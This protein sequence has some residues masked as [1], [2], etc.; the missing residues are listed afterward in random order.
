MKKI[1][2]YN[3]FI[4][5]IS[6]ISKRTFDKYNI[7]NINNILPILQE[8]YREYCSY[9]SIKKGYD[10][11]YLLEALSD[12][13]ISSKIENDEISLS[14]S[15]AFN[16]FKKLNSITKNYAIIITKSKKE[17][18]DLHIIFNGEFSNRGFWG[19]ETM[20]YQSEWHWVFKD[21]ELSGT[22]GHSSLETAIRIG[23]GLPIFYYDDY[24][25]SLNK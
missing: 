20:N 12:Y 11:E 3:N 7:Q 13:I 21:N 16:H 5:E 2:K 10:Y 22:S 14:I 9:N 15:L 24:L 18:R 1:N 6:T 19:D 25:K 17:V 8:V 23:K 4:N